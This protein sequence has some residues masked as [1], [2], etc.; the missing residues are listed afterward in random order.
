MA[1]Y[2]CEIVL[3]AS[4]IMWKEDITDT[5]GK[6]EGKKQALL[7]ANRFLQWLDE[8]DVEEDEKDEEAKPKPK[9]R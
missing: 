7:H 9:P 4:F 1:I 2:D 3:E 5:P 6:K 8:A